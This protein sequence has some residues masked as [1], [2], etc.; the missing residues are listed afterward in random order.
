MKKK[1]IIAL[2]FL[3]LSTLFACGGSDK[4]SQQN[5]EV[6]TDVGQE[7]KDELTEVN[8]EAVNTMDSLSNEI[9]SAENKVDN[10]LESL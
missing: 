5:E 7:V 10:L 2:S 9:D 8:I 1:T 6:T 3:A 4:N